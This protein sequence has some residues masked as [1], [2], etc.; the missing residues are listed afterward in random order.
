MRVLRLTGFD[1]SALAEQPS[2]VHTT[3]AAIFHGVTVLHRV[4]TGPSSPNAKN[5]FIRG[6]EGTYPARSIMG[7]FGLVATRPSRRGLSRGS[8]CSALVGV[9][10]GYFHRFLA[11]GDVAHHYG[12]ASFGIRRSPSSRMGSTAH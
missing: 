5:A 11:P 7:E 8:P 9:L 4:C 6:E 2:L 3:K 10:G 12:L 1:T